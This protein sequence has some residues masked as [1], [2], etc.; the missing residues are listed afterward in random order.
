MRESE[1]VSF[2]LVNMKK[3]ET[4]GRQKERNRDRDQK[5]QDLLQNGDCVLYGAE[6]MDGWMHR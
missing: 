2:P 3:R 4:R 1:G 6:W 5:E